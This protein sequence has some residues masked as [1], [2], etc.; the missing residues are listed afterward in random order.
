MTAITREEAVHPLLAQVRRHAEEEKVEVLS[1]FEGTQSAALALVEAMTQRVQGLS[2]AAETGWLSDRA[3]QEEMLRCLQELRSSMEV[4]RTRKSD[5]VALS[6]GCSTTEIKHLLRDI[7]SYTTRFG[8]EPSEDLIKEWLLKV[9]GALETLLNRPVVKE[10]SLCL[11]PKE[12]LSPYQSHGLVNGAYFYPLYKKY[13]ELREKC[14]RYDRS[15]LYLERINLGVIS[16]S[17]F[18]EI[19]KSCFRALKQL[20]NRVSQETSA[21][22]LEKLD[23]R[24]MA[25]SRIDR[26]KSCYQVDISL[27]IKKLKSKKEGAPYF[28]PICTPHSIHNSVFVYGFVAD[29]GLA[30]PNLLQSLNGGCH[31]IIGEAKSESYLVTNYYRFFE[32]EDRVSFW[33]GVKIKALDLPFFH[34]EWPLDKLIALDAR[35][36]KLEIKDFVGF[37]QILGVIE[38]YCF[39]RKCKKRCIEELSFLRVAAKEKI[40]TEL[41]AIERQLNILKEVGRA[42]AYDTS[43]IPDLLFN[44][45]P[46]K[47][48]LPPEVEEIEG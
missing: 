12:G 10:P 39:I 28:S 3:V 17:C 27:G 1:R 19:T 15:G 44:L 30:Y 24:G 9:G 29:K 40:S 33:T 41:M 13:R 26:M 46:K 35:S 22:L 42:M 5:V 7:D 21:T 48:I 43:L 31:F 8:M 6:C 18:I 36:K 11:F 20:V 23:Q 45:D 2:R 34:I 38:T 47:D 25:I 16:D 4:G 37:E 32:E 14:E